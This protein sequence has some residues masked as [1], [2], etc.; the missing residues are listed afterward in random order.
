MKAE[1]W[2]YMDVLPTDPDI[3]AEPLMTVCMGVRIDPQ[4][5]LTVVVTNGATQEEMEVQIADVEYHVDQGYYVCQCYPYRA[6]PGSDLSWLE[7]YG[8]KREE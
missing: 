1:T 7:G 4:R 6:L 3:D 5:D 2:L 8:W